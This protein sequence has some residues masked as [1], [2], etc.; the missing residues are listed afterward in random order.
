MRNIV[1]N[2]FLFCF[3]GI[4]IGVGLYFGFTKGALPLYEGI[5]TKEWHKT[6]ATLLDLS[7]NSKTRKGSTVSEVLTRYSYTFEG[8]KYL[9]STIIKGYSYN[10]SDNNNGLWEKLRSAKTIEVY[11]N[12]KNA[13]EA[14]IIRGFSGSSLAWLMFSIVWASLIFVFFVIPKIIPPTHSFRYYW[15]GGILIWIALIMTYLLIAKDID[16]EEETTVVQKKNKKEMFL[17]ERQEKI[18]NGEPVDSIA[19]EDTTEDESVE[20]IILTDT[21]Q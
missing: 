21:A 10:N 16:L 4:L 13:A 19:P 5:K 9:D 11:V 2:L 6:E 12:P 3:A 18:N 17:F 1:A 15:G 7:I 14:V 20:E 8:R